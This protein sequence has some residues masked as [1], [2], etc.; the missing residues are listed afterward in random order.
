MIE[1]CNIGKAVLTKALGLQKNY[2]E[3]IETSYEEELERLETIR[4]LLDPLANHELLLQG[5]AQRKYTDIDL[6]RIDKI[7]ANLSC[8]FKRTL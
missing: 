8:E 3:M 2:S 7:Q 6:K 4:L 5:L 1:F